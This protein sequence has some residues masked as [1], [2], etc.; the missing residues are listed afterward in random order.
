MCSAFVIHLFS[1]FLRT[2]KFY[3]SATLEMHFWKKNRNE[4]P[5]PMNGW[6]LG[7]LT[8]NFKKNVWVLC[9]AAVLT[10]KFSRDLQGRSLLKKKLQ[11]WLHQSGCFHLAFCIQ[12]TMLLLNPKLIWGGGLR[13]SIQS[14][15]TQWLRVTGSA[16]SYTWEEK[17]VQ[18][19]EGL[20]W[21]AELSSP[22]KEDW[23][24]ISGT[25][26]DKSEETWGRFGQKCMFWSV[27]SLEKFLQC[28][29]V[30]EQVL[31]NPAWNV[32]WREVRKGIKNGIHQHHRR[33]VRRLF[34]AGLLASVHI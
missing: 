19:N 25:L 23:Q 6:S 18:W 24:E 3:F 4:K 29:H 13:G 20:T 21:S 30:R 34:P 9:S 27:K 1:L 12:L 16:K 8:L 22:D 11:E 15:I 17:V 14:G 10:A 26:P 7:L 28:T 2:I 31:G 32:A 5:F 33:W